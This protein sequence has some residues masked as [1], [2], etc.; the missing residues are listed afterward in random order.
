[1]EVFGRVENLTDQSHQEV[2]G[3]NGAGRAAYAGVRARF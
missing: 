3:F 1:V 2:Y